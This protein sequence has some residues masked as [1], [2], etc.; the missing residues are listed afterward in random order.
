MNEFSTY[1]EKR[2]E[3]LKQYQ[4]ATNPKAT[5]PLKQNIFL[6]DLCMVLFIGFIKAVQA[7]VADIQG[8]AELLAKLKAENEAREV[9]IK[10]MDESVKTRE[11]HLK[12]FDGVKEDPELLKELG[13]RSIAEQVAELRAIFADTDAQRARLVEASRQAAKTAE[14]LQT[15]TIL[16]SQF[17][18]HFKIE[19]IQKSLFDD[20]YK[21][22]DSA[23]VKDAIQKFIGFALGFVPMVNEG[24][25]VF[26]F[27]NDLK[28]I[29][30]ERLKEIETINDFHN[31][32]DHYALAATQ[33]SLTTQVLVDIIYAMTRN[34]QPSLE[35]S[36]AKLHQIIELLKKDWH[37]EIPVIGQS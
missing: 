31:Y 15:L 1:F 8:K 28:S 33:W 22:R 20:L 3:F 32:L 13:L 25:A 5:E 26:Q 24:F 2:N 12:K 10:Q 29:Y 19:E 18:L 27:L 37:P 23:A 6:T 11:E 16:A 35:A 34:E 30:E 36:E 17:F 9:L 7:G 14:E 4:K 21:A